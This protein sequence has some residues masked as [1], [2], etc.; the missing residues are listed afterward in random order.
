MKWV[1]V[2]NS[3]LSGCLAGHSAAVLAGNIAALVLLFVLA[4]LSRLG[5]ADL[6]GHILTVLPGDKLA[7]PVVHSAALHLG[8]PLGH[9]AAHLLGQHSAH[10][11]AHLLAVLPAHLGAD[12]AGDA[13][14]VLLGDHL[15]ACAGDGLAHLPLLLLGHNATSLS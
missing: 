4:D 10:G 14:T 12:L 1:N 9:H 15:A 5:G 13:L 6:S 7:L 11:L 8:L 2:G 3:H